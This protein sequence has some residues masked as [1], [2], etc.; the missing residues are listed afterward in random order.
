MANILMV[1]TTQDRLGTTGSLTGLWFE[2]FVTPYYLFGDAGATITLASPLG[3]P[4]AV[5]PRSDGPSNQAEAVRR[6]RQ[7]RNA[8]S[9]LAD[10]LRLEQLD[11][12]D[13]DGAFYPGGAGA[14]WDLADDLQSASLLSALHAS[15]TPI[16]LVGYGVAA[17]RRAIDQDTHPLV[18]GRTV[19]GLSNSEERAA[20][21]AGM[22]PFSLEDEL[23]RLGA[24]YRK[25]PD[26]APH[27]IRDGALITGQNTISAAGVARKLLDTPR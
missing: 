17:L 2:D 15:G 27:V 20:G 22:V 10:T 12:K 18:E 3:G 9:A 24:N 21:L 16:A 4:A 8:R 14:M 5:D 6:F 19:T 1:V 11:P 13:F 7:D 23:I 25:G 26:G